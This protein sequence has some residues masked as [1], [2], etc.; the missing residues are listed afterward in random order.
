[1]KKVVS[2]ILSFLIVF[3]VSITSF[4]STTAL[5]NQIRE[6]E[7]KNLKKVVENFISSNMSVTFL[8]KGNYDMVDKDSIIF[9]EYLIKR[10]KAMDLILRESKEVTVT[11]NSTNEET[12][13]EEYDISDDENNENIKNIS[14]KVTELFNYKGEESKPKASISYNVKLL[15]VK[16]EDGWKVWVADTDNKLSNPYDSNYDIF[17]KVPR[18][19]SDVN[20]NS[21]VRRTFK[22]NNIGKNLYDLNKYSSDWEKNIVDAYK[23]KVDL[24]KSHSVDDEI[25]YESPNIDDTSSALLRSSSGSVGRGKM[26]E[27]M[28]KYARN[29]NTAKYIFFDRGD[30]ANFGSQVLY[31]GGATP[32]GKVYID[33]E[34]RLWGNWPQSVLHP[35]RY[36]DA[37]AQ[38]NYLMAFIL[39]NDGIGPQGYL[40][41]DG[42]DLVTGDFTFLNNGSRWFHTTIVTHG[43]GSNDPRIACHSPNVFDRRLYSFDWGKRNEKGYVKI[44]YLY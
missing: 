18:P 15:M 1:M 21:D 9:K 19:V 7:D 5:D 20:A 10:N 17:S 16:R 34:Y 12:L 11:G 4:A 38:A 13:F 25:T 8:S 40:M 29:P 44:K 41:K 24:E 37:W 32:G 31:E 35:T 14:V 23:N 22:H 42:K 33:G 3:S 28:K 43:T 27:Y 2:F 36:G 39:N 26:F 30:C 6:S